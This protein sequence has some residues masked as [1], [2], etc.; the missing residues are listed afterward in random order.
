MGFDVQPIE[1]A[2]DQLDWAI[3]LLID[4]QAYVPAITLSGAAN[5]ILENCLRGFG[6][7]DTAHST[8]TN[9]LSAS[10]YGSPDQIGKIMNA[11]RNYLKHGTVELIDPSDVDLKSEAVQ[12]VTQ[13]IINLLRLEKSFTSETVRFFEWLESRA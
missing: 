6:G 4:H 7:A 5:G 12:Q 8:L 2:V 1:A 9:A 10:G 13:A 11:A 3:R